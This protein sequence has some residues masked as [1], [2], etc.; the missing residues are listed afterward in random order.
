[1]KSDASI[2]VHSAREVVM[3][4]QVIEDLVYEHL[5][6]LID[7]ERMNEL[8][9]IVGMKLAELDGRHHDEPTIDMFERAAALMERAWHRLIED[10]RRYGDY[11]GSWQA[12]DDCAICRALAEADG[13]K[14]DERSGGGLS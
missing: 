2:P 4:E 3:T 11:R 7:F 13:A 5:F 10:E 6:D 12:D 9:E 14:P 1:M 8:E